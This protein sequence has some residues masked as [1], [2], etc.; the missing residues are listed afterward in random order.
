MHGFFL[1]VDE[2]LTSDLA[3]KIEGLL[4][5]N[6][7]NEFNTLEDVSAAA[8]KGEFES[9]LFIISVTDIYISQSIG[10]RYRYCSDNCR[11]QHFYQRRGTFLASIK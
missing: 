4:A 11:N 1:I 3:S 6:N 7:G 5:G 8:S 9:C 2:G 10:C